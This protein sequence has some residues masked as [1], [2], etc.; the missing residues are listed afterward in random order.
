MKIR[1]RTLEDILK[2]FLFVFFSF[3]ALVFIFLYIAKIELIAKAEGVIEAENW[4]EIRPKVGGIIKEMLVSEGDKVKRG[5]LL[6]KLEDGEKKTVLLNSEL[7]LEKLILEKKEM[8]ENILLFENEIKNKIAEQESSLSAAQSELKL[9]MKGS[10]I[11]EIEVARAKVEMASLSARQAE[12]EYKRK[13]EESELGLVSLKKKEEAK[14]QWELAS[15]DLEV[16]KKNLLLI[17]NRYSD[18]EKKV[19]LSKVKEAEARLA[20]IRDEEKKGEFLRKG[21]LKI[22]K[23]IEMKEN[24]IE[25][26]K[27]TVMNFSIYSEVNGIILTKETH[28][29]I[30]RFVGQGETVLKIGRAKDYIIKAF[31]KEKDRPKVKCGQKAKIFVKAFPHGEY[32]IFKGQVTNISED[33]TKN[34]SYGV[35]ITVFDPYVIRDGKLYSLQ[36]GYTVTSNIITEK[37]RI[38][39]IL[40]KLL[41]RIKGEIMPKNIY[42]ME[43][44]EE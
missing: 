1:F 6:F 21:I 43:E 23:E 18:E 3:L 7:E 22:E 15:A 29:L 20:Q 39:K 8:E 9:I 30:G 27:K 36:I 12:I 25:F 32:K 37:D 17:Q 4:I 26:L 40:I 38:I 2:V 10:K 44:K 35:T 11:E 31:I 34:G 33:R 5:D 19:A 13:K 42:F 16:A 28:H 24:E 41:K 14:F